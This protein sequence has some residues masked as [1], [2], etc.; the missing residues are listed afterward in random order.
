MYNVRIYVQT[1]KEKK[2]G[3]AYTYTSIARANSR[4]ALEAFH[5]ANKA[6]LWSSG[7]TVGSQ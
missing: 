2:R 7:S 5:N 3:V 6:A 4:F 1:K